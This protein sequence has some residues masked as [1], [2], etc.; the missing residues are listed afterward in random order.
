[1]HTS[2]IHENDKCGYCDDV[3]N[4]PSERHIN[5]A[6]KHQVGENYI[7]LE[8]NINKK[9]DKK[10]DKS[11]HCLICRKLYKEPSYL[12]KHIK[13]VHKEQ[14]TMSSQCFILSL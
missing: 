4:S 8:E 13:N 1:M 9:V 5:I 12:K 3:L 7:L 10:E 2:R 11:F 6:H 14:V